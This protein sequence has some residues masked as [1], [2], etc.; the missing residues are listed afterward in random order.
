MKAESSPS[1]RAGTTRAPRCGAGTRN[2]AECCAVGARRA[3]RRRA[4]AGRDLG[5]RDADHARLERL[6]L[7]GRHAAT[8]RCDD[9]GFVLYRNGLVLALHALA[10]VAG[11]MAG[12][13][14]PQVA[15]GYSGSGARSTRR[16]ARW[17]SAS[18][19]RDAVLALHPGL[20]ARPRRRRP[21]RRSCDISPALLLIGL[22]PARAA[23]A[24][25]AVPAAGRLD[26]S[27]A[28]AAHGT[29]CSPPRSSR[30]DRGP[31]LWSPPRPSRSG[32]PPPG[33]R[34]WPG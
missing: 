7:P 24:D 12:S 27:P 23:G 22:L 4:A 5:G 21:R 17:R 6:R 33:A 15:E 18:C 32:S 10:C 26:A 1:S 16:P 14:L 9:F 34:S 28:A 11:F 3:R 25:R 19:L 20:R 13:S 30:R 29:S 8:R 2:P 31:G